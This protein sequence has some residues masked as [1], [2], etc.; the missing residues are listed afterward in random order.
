MNEIVSDETEDEDRVDVEEFWESVEYN[1]L[2]RISPNRVIQ[3]LEI[4]PN[5]N[6]WAPYIG[7]YTKHFKIVLNTEHKKV[8]K[9]NGK[10]EEDC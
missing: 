8:S 5:F 2:A 6:Y 1:I 10:F 4:K 9:I 3:E 7:K